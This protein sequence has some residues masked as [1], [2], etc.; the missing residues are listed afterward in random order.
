MRKTIINKNKWNS[1][2]FHL[3]PIVKIYNLEILLSRVWKNNSDTTSSLLRVHFAFIAFLSTCDMTHDRKDNSEMTS[4]Q[5]AKQKKK[6]IDNINFFQMSF[7]TGRS[8]VSWPSSFSSWATP[9]L[10]GNWPSTFHVLRF[11]S[12]AKMFVTR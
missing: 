11:I 3:L 9:V 10:T 4:L 8:V 7:S 2:M 12:F 1:K 5:K 6:E